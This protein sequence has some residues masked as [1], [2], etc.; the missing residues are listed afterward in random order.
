MGEENKTPPKIDTQYLREVHYEW[1]NKCNCYTCKHRMS[2][3]L[4]DDF[5]CFLIWIEDRQN[6][7]HTKQA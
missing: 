5:L 2:E 4:G 1:S 6:E 7:K 3:C